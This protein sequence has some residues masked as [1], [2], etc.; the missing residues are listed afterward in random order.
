MVEV[1]NQWLEGLKSGE[2]EAARR[3]VREF[4]GPLLRYLA[5]MVKNAADAEELTQE[6]FVRFL[7][8]LSSFRGDCSIK[9]Y[10]FRIAHNLALNHFASAAYIH[11]THPGELPASPSPE[12]PPGTALGLEEG[13]I[14]V[15]RAV[16]ALPPQQRSVVILRT[17]QE[18]TFKEIASVLSLAEGTV[19]AHYFFGLRGLRRLLEDHDEP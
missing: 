2:E 11:E 13:A 6:T 16:E 15:R 19:K 9:S 3:L 14:P 5:T 4:G 8:G 18:L 17:W 12:A 7:N 1:L 10:L